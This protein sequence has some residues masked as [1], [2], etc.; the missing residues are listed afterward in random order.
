MEKKGAEQPL[1]K[2]V[3]G[4]C[5]VDNFLLSYLGPTGATVN[6]DSITPVSPNIDPHL[7]MG[8]QCAKKTL[9]SIKKKYKDGALRTSAF[10]RVLMEQL[11]LE[12]DPKERDLIIE[13]LF[14]VKRSFYEALQNK[15]IKDPVLHK[16]V[17]HYLSFNEL[18]GLICDMEKLTQ[19]NTPYHVCSAMGNNL[20]LY[21]GIQHPLNLP[22]KWGLQF[23][24]SQK[25]IHNPQIL[26][27]SCALNSMLPLA[28]LLKT[29]ETNNRPLVVIAPSFQEE[30]WSSYLY[31][32]ARSLMSVIPLPLDASNP[33]YTKTIEEIAKHSHA[34]IFN[35]AKELSKA[36]P[37]DIGDQI[38]ALFIS[39]RSVYFRTDS[40]EHEQILQ[41]N[42]QKKYMDEEVYYSE[43]LKTLS[44]V[45][46]CK[47]QG[48]CAGGGIGMLF[49]SQD[50]PSKN[51]TVIEKKALEIFR[52]AVAAI[53]SRIIHNAN[54]N[55][56]PYK[57]MLLKSGYPYGFNALSKSI[58]DF[59]L[60][61]LYDS[62]ELINDM[63][64][65]SL[66]EAK[67]LFST[68]SIL[69]S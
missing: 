23:S 8:M 49:A 7:V 62:I 2:V 14:E 67:Q 51:R 68:S 34:K 55:P 50:L 44:H 15:K 40:K 27:L 56:L 4:I 60:L 10:F 24:Y 69:V 66:K 46:S 45:H 65:V 1:S 9:T 31:N 18:D 63:I 54:C 33:R 43:I 30:A 11:I 38:N 41:I 59:T 58:E 21:N 13:G 19:F 61:Y 47:Q 12:N 35:S 25:P 6:L 39:E 36:T 32:S 52:T 3:E 42:L 20:E 16:S 28:H 37:E 26:I 57:K 22:K 53:H 17:I 48:V 5:R 29:V 64:D